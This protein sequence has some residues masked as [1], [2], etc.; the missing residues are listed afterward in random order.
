V[1]TTTRVR[2]V[3]ERVR[4]RVPAPLRATLERAGEHHTLT[5]AAGLAFFGILSI[6]PAVGVGFGLL[7]VLVSPEAADSIVELLEDGFPQQLGLGDLIDQMED[8]GARYAG[9]GLV[10]LLWPATT[11][12]SGWA[13]ALDAIMDADAL[14]GVRGLRGRL[15]GLV[16]GGI[17]VAGLFLLL[18]A[19]TFGTALVGTA[20]ALF[21]GGLLVAAIALQYVFNLVIYRLLP[22]TKR[23]W[24]SLWR[25]AVVATAGVGLVTAGFAI[26]LGVGEGLAERYPPALTTSIVLGIWLYGANI[27]L[28]LG[29]EYNEVHWERRGDAEA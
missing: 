23:P 18:A 2:S 5:L 13:R 21:L 26:A 14:P 16:P 10:V 17:L 12:A 24:R 15:Q 22:S 1:E 9:V 3:A 28:L 4:E 25:G 7:R 8:R 20:G 19:V 27:A 6:G 29:A 11:L